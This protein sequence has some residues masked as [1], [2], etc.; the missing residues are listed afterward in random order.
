MKA[1][2]AGLSQDVQN[3][4][5]N[6]LKEKYLDMNEQGLSNTLYR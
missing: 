2:W 5:L 3:A 1:S 4:I 6:S